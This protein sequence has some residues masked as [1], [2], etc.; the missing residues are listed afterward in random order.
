MSVVLVVEDEPLIRMAACMIVE[1]AGFIA[2]E[3]ANADD[4]IRILE[5]R[6]DIRLIFTDVDMP[7]SLD[8]LKLAHFVRNRWPPIKIIVASGKAMLPKANF[9]K[10]RGS[11]Q[12][13]M[14]TTQ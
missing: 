10:A 5:S 12:S 1:D 8:G 2:L 11:F 7:G 4:A 9:R 6:S 3:A 13:P 14:T